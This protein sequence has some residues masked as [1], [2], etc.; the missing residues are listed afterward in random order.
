M[1]RIMK[2]YLSI[3]ALSLC[4]TACRR[5]TVYGD[6]KIQEISADEFFKLYYEKRTWRYNPVYKGKR[7]DWHVI[8]LYEH[9]GSPIDKTETEF[10]CRIS[11]LPSKFPESAQRK[12][13]EFEPAR[14][15]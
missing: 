11:E 14:L 15:R 9:Y 1:T 12:L 4:F 8:I 10:R 3:V 7:A 2:V 5:Q 6:P 13:A